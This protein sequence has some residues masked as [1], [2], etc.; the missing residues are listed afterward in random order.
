M[1]GIKGRM[2]ARLCGK[3]ETSVT[4]GPLAPRRA[5]AEH[6]GTLAALVGALQ[7]PAPLVVSAALAAL[8]NLLLVRAVHHTCRHPF[9]QSPAVPLRMGML[10]TVHRPLLCARGMLVW[11]AF[12][13]TC[14]RRYFKIVARLL[15]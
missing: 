13:R 10:T 1:Q 14:T 2:A 5:I 11:L 9:I 7:S 15:H 6:P 12:R 4:R 3:Q 8:N